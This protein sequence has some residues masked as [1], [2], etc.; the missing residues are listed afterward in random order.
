MR[1]PRKMSR[2]TGAVVSSVVCGALAF[3]ASG[4]ALA[5]A[6]DDSTHAAGATAAAPIPGAD[7][8]A[9]QTR[10]LGGLGSVLQPVTDLVDAVLKS[11]D[12]KLPTP[13]AA[14]HAEAVKEALAK[15]TAAAKAPTASASTLP[16]APEAPVAPS[17]PEVPK[18]PVDPA[19]P[20]TPKTQQTQKTQKQQTSEL[21][22]APEASA[23]PV[24]PTNAKAP[25]TPAAPKV[26]PKAGQQGAPS[27]AA[28]KPELVTKAVTDLQAKVNALLKATTDGSPA[29]VAT[30]LKT[31]L[32]A[33][34]NVVTSTLLGGGLPAPDLPGLPKLPAAPKTPGLPS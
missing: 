21:P 11:P 3:G 22:K 6:H 17:A 2:K 7:A 26:A 14:K 27:Q 24:D 4:A 18:T 20:K 31:T 30:A 32:T 25:E 1:M 29:E 16:K 13:E 15:I 9:G 10:L 12:G 8:L 33:T 28:P 5:T 23:P 34:V 19:S